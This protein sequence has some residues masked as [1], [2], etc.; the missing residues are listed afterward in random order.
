MEGFHREALAAVAAFEA[1]DLAIALSSVGSVVRIPGIGVGSL[2]M[3]G[4]GGVGAKGGDKHKYSSC[5]R[6]GFL[7]SIYRRNAALDFTFPSFGALKKINSMEK[8]HCCLSCRS[9]SVQSYVSRK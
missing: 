8:L 5:K 1:G 7:P 9:G 3:V 6:L 4:A 2:L